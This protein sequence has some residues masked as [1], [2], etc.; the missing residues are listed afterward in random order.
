MRGVPVMKKGLE[1]DGDKPMREKK[2][3]DWHA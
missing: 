2:E 3:E 1:K